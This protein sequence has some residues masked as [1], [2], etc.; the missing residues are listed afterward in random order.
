MYIYPL[1]PL[2]IIGNKFFIVT[3]ADKLKAFFVFLVVTFN[4]FPLSKQWCLTAQSKFQ[5][6]FY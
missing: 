2:D 6:I 5:L 4:D 3:Y 1:R